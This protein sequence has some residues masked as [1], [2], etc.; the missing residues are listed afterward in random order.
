LGVVSTDLR[1]LWQAEDQ[2]VDWAVEYRSSVEEPWRSAVAQV[3][4]S[5]AAPGVAPHRVYRATLSGLP[6][7]GLFSYRVSRANRLRFSAEVGAIKTSGQP[8]RFVAF[9]DCGAGPAEQRLIAYQAYLA[10]PDFIMIT[11][12]IVY[13]RG[14]IAEYIEKFWPVYNADVASPEVGAPLLRSTLFL[15]APGNHD[16]ATRD[17]GT[18]PDGLAYSLYWAQPLN[19]PIGHEGGPLVPP[20][21]APSANRRAFLQAAGPAYPRMANYSFEYGNA[22]WTILDA[23]SYVDWTDPDLRGWVERDL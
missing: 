14:R 9:G 3:I 11:G 10:R 12:D 4:R 22:H 19:G 2:D 8:Y 21:V 16:V 18:Y 5:V 20:L 17:L 15:A 13:T 7:R 6:P 23:N 1:L